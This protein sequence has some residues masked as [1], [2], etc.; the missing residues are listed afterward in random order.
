[1]YSFDAFNVSGHHLV[2]V[3]IA[4]I[5]RIVLEQF[6]EAIKNVEDESLKPTLDK[7]ASLFALSVIEK[8]KGWYLEDGYMEGVKTKAIRK[9]VN[10]LSWELR[11]D[12][13]ALTEVFD[14]PENC[15]AAA[16]A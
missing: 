4:Y 16:I 13:V 15:L 6:H 3:G 12:A 11:K 1:M 2:N 8:N 7:L 10:Q 9:M 5:E 14:I